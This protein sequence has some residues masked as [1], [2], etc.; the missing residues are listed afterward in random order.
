MGIEQPVGHLGVLFQAATDGGPDCLP[1]LATQ[2]RQFVDM[3]SDATHA[4]H[5]A[6]ARRDFD[7]QAKLVEDALLQVPQLVQAFQ[8]LESFEQALFFIA[9]QAQDAQVGVGDR[10]QAFAL[11]DASAGWAGLASGRGHGHERKHSQT[12]GYLHWGCRHAGASSILA[13][14]H[15]F[16]RP[17]MSRSRL[18]VRH[19]A[20]SILLV[21]LAACSSQRSNQPPAP[22]PEQVRAKLV[23]LLP[24]KVTDR[25]G[26]AADIETALNVQ[27]IPG[28]DENLCAVL[29]VA[30]Q[31]STFQVDPSVPGLGKIARQEIDRRAGRVHVPG[32]LVDAA[33][34]IRSGD[35]KSYA[36]RLEAARSEK[37]LSEIFDDFTGMVP[38]GRQLFGTFNP[39]R[40]G[41]PMQVSIDFAEKH[42]ARYPYTVDGSIRREV[43][44]RRGGMYFGIAHLLGYPATYERPLYRFADFNAGWYASRNAAFQNAVNQ[45]SGG[46]LALDGD[47]IRYDS[48]AASNTELAVRNLG[49][50][51]NMNDRDIRR[52]LEEGETLDFEKTTLFQRTFALADK[53]AGKPVPRAI[54]PGIKLQSPKITRNLTTAWFAQR[55]DERYARC[56]T[57]AR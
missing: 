28:S 11:A 53:A 54:L 32:F 14:I 31:E 40:T 3:D 33:L 8:V 17:Y 55:V 21:L 35:G 4:A 15:P 10:V 1:R 25:E 26:W 39:V 27:G 52:A 46:R 19:G 43:F 49:N 51:L 41:G 23:Q 6:C 24:A 13:Q 20:L 18:A 5:G 44:T 34:G 42:R 36:Q 50:R 9:G 38:L 37:Q 45:L 56:M 22:S 48:S 7:A 12:A 57:R 30:E 47:L 29:A 16:P 2:S